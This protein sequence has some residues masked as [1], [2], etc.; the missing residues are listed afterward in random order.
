MPPEAVIATLLGTVGTL[1]TIV[2][3]FYRAHLADDDKDEKEWTRREAILIAERDA[4]QHRWEA[5]DARL[6]RI[7]AAFLDAFKKPA[8]E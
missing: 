8:P 1:S 5:H 4:W 7:S 3:Y 6:A 2:A